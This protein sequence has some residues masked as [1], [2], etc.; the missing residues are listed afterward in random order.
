M[1][2]WVDGRLGVPPGSMMQVF[3]PCPGV[4]WHHTGEHG[5]PIHESGVHHI[6]AAPSARSSTIYLSIF[7]PHA[8]KRCKYLAASFPSQ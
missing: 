4:Q 7:Y 2:A 6:L 3:L 8:A 1:E 5:G